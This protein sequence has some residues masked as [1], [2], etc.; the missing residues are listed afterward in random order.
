MNSC[1]GAIALTSFTPATTWPVSLS[2]DHD[3]AT[4]SRYAARTSGILDLDVG[5]E[6][7]IR[8][9]DVNR[10]ERD[11]ALASSTPSQ[12]AAGEGQGVHVED[13]ARFPVSIMTLMDEVRTRDGVEV[14]A[15]QVVLCVLREPLLMRDQLFLGIGQAR[16]VLVRAPLL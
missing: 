2:R 10:A 5:T 16:R 3:F 13:V 9:Q 1:S 14:G 11:L 12:M 7:R 8:H 6:R 4:P 15:K